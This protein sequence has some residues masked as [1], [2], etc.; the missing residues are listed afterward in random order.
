MV[1]SQGVPPIR[2]L[3]ET[4]KSL[5]KLD[6]KH[7][8]YLKCGELPTLQD[9]VKEVIGEKPGLDAYGEKSKGYSPSKPE[10]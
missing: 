6:L 3:L 5:K 8:M 2:K 4:R 7:F 10:T 1:K 9:I